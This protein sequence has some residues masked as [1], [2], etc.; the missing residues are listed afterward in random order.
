MEYKFSRLPQFFNPKILS[1]AKVVVVDHSPVPPLT[2]MGLDGFWGFEHGNYAGITYKDTYFIRA[3][4]AWNESLHF[5]ELVHVV[6][7]KILGVE[8]FLRQYAFGILTC[9]YY[10]SP[11]EEMARD[12]QADFD[13]GIRPF[14]V[15]YVL[16]QK[17]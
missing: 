16:T 15:G 9:G 2:S 3:S 12:F 14:D 10:D 13:R 1:E 8:K 5:H 11:L 17:L 4:E 7:W 6:Q